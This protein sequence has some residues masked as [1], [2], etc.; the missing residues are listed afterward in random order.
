MSNLQ[1]GE[2]LTFQRC[3]KGTGCGPTGCGKA[4]AFRL[5]RTGAKMPIDPLPS[6]QGTIALI[7]PEGQEIAEV[8]TADRCDGY[9]GHLYQ[10]HFETCE[11]GAKFRKNR[12]P[13]RSPYPSQPGTMA[14]VADKLV[15]DQIKAHAAWFVRECREKGLTAREAVGDLFAEKHPKWWKDERNR[16]A[17][18]TW[19]QRVRDIAR[20]ELGFAEAAA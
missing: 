17:R 10:T 11:D 1:P 14:N 7:G 19:I 8:L 5:T 15:G 3:N 9:E 4:I 13:K 16:K 2:L 18:T 20:A 6:Q 12:P